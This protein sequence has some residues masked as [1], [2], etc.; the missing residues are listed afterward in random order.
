MC[1][2]N[3]YKVVPLGKDLEKKIQVT[4]ALIKKKR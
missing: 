1:V 4:S 2:I 3:S